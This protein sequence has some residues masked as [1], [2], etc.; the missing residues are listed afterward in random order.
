MLAPKKQYAVVQSSISVWAMQLP[1]VRL[2]VYPGECL[3]VLRVS[4]LYIQRARRSSVI[5]AN[6][7][8]KWE[9]RMGT[10]ISRRFRGVLILLSS[11]LLL[12]IPALY[13]PFPEVLKYW[14]LTLGFISILHIYSVYPPAII[15]PRLSRGIGWATWILGFGLTLSVGYLQLVQEA[16]D[17]L[18]LIFIFALAFPMLGRLMIFVFPGLV[19]FFGIQLAL[20]WLGK[21]FAANVTWIAIAG[22]LAFAIGSLA[23]LWIL[24]AFQVQHHQR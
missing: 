24:K 15:P 12:A 22:T 13:F 11:I 14:A 1:Y 6:L 2:P 18:A 3:H 4:P 5:C 20:M 16:F 9:H 23:G 10:Q 19:L 17:G 7:I 21:P 8:C